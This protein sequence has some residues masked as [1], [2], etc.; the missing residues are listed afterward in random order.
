M[1]KIQKTLKSR[2][3]SLYEKNVYLQ[4]QPTNQT[5]ME[6]KMISLCIGVLLA[7]LAASSCSSTCEC[8]LYEYGVAVS[9]STEVAQ[10]QSC[11]EFS[12]V[13]ETPDGKM[14]MEC[15]KKK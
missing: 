7:A 2:N 12:S 4:L 1:A 5:L 9:S 14:G 8:T 10:G 11:S 6:K 3:G 15:V 13:A